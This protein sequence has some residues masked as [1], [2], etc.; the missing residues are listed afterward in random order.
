[1]QS[2]IAYK[3]RLLAILTSLTLVFTMSFSTITTFAAEEDL[4]VAVENEQQADELS[5]ADVVAGDEEDGVVKA[6]GDG[7]GDDP[8]DEEAAVLSGGE[9][10]TE[11]G[12]FTLADDASGIITINGGLDVTIYGG[13]YDESTDS[14]INP[15]TALSFVVGDEAALTIEDLYVSAPSATDS[16]SIIDFT[17]TGTLNISGHNL[18]DRPAGYVNAAMI[19]VG[20]DA[21]V[22]FDGDGILWG[23]KESAGSFIGSNINEV[24]GNI[25]FNGG[26]WL[27]KVNKTGALIGQDSPAAAT[28]E[29]V[30]NDGVLYLKSISYASILG[31]S[32]Q[33][34]APNVTING[35]QLE[36]Y[37]DWKGAA[38]G[39]SDM[40]AGAG[41][42]SVNGGSIRTIS[43]QNAYST[44]GVDANSN[45]G[46]VLTD[47]NITADHDTAMLAFDATQYA[48]VFFDSSN[49]KNYY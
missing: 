9:T 43:G 27:L 33:G 28:G 40:S 6:L 5:P 12:E 41:T 10:I 31:S 35:G 19:H 4:N 20:K 16:P 44:W 30:I 29:I 1:M 25:T 32:R 23:Y 21:D 42:F 47:A 22:A 38:I 11:D 26:T 24:C 49:K 17:G 2:N 7:D 46:A 34:Q 14:F 37:T 13:N 45:K 36:L 39:G 18:L 8:I 15:Y 48:E 3:K